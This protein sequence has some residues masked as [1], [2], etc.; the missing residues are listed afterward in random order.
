MGRIR[1]RASK[2]KDTDKPS[3]RKNVE[4]S[5]PDEWDDPE[6]P[7]LVTLKKKI[8]NTKK[9][10]DKLLRLEK[11]DKNDLNDAQLKAL[12]RLN[13]TMDY[14][15][16]V[17]SISNEMKNLARE[18]IKADEQVEEKQRIDADGHLL[19]PEVELDPI[20]LSERDSLLALL[21]VSN[22]FSHIYE[23]QKTLLIEMNQIGVLATNEELNGLKT[24]SS[25]LCG[26]LYEEGS[27]PSE[28]FNNAILNFE[29]YLSMSPEILPV[30][31]ISYKRL[32]IV[33]E[34]VLKTPTWRKMEVPV[35]Y[36]FSF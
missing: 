10:L 30:A 3:P 27:S 22:C 20:V 29:R 9:K 17:V 28:K 36:P 8:R 23:S 12:S 16:T 1:K 7:Y 24:I 4:L 26:Q 32:R 15:N 35:D 14:Y 34:T 31:G 5:V 18:L 6:N 21:H 25:A 13:E 11:M 2:P 19:A 33:A